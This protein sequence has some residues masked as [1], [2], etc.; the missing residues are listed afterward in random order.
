MY[1]LSATTA[2]TTKTP[3]SYLM[4]GGSRVCEWDKGC[5]RRKEDRRYDVESAK[6]IRRMMDDMVGRVVRLAR[7]QLGNF[8]FFLLLAWAYVSVAFSMKKKLCILHSVEI[9]QSVVHP[10]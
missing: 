8:F 3:H 10:I 7:K 1:A 9:T 2:K 5:K 6:R 4:M